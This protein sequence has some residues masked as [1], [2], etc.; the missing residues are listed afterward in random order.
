MSAQDWFV[1][2]VL[3]LSFKGGVGKPRTKIMEAKATK[4]LSL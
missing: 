1:S 4:S 2:L 3:A